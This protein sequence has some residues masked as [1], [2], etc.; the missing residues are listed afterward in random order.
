M[1]ILSNIAFGILVAFTYLTMLMLLVAAHE[2]GHYLFARLFGMGAEEF[3]VGMFGKKPLAILGK[4]RYLIPLK[5]DD[6]PDFRGD[7]NALEG[8]TTTEPAEVVETPQGKA[9]R[10]TT[11]FTIR[12]WPLGGFVRIK[13]M[14][15]QED[16]GETRVPGGFFSKP[17]IQRWI[18]LAAGPAFSVL[19]G[20][21]LLIPY[22]MFYGAP[23]PSPKPVFGMLQTD[24]A[25]YKAKMD[26]G[27]RVVSIDGKPV[28][29]WY[30][31]V[32]NVR[33]T[34]GRPLSIV[35]I[36]DGKQLQ[37][38]VKGKVDTEPTLV[39]DDKGKPTGE[40]RIQTK[41]GALPSSDPK[42]LSF[43]ESVKVATLMPIY[44]TANLI[45]LITHPQD[46]KDNVGGPGTMVKMTAKSVREGLW[47]V[48]ARAGEISI[49]LGIF[50]LLPIPP[51]D[52]GQMWI[53]FVEMLR[54]GRRLSM[55][56][57]MRVLNLGFAMVAALIVGVLMIDFGRLTGLSSPPKITD[58]RR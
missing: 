15:P 48:I 14:V 17:P 27:D 33:D 45:S 57:Q 55:R 3:A 58:E 23:D 9:L 31:M 12:P 47:P 38:T 11:V 36:R 22:L 18:V 21:L 7:T 19:A 37:F 26:V 34:N 2:L 28:K 32:K 10:E 39:V 20:I 6:D 24:G 30:D 49:S 51:L 35:A 43:G 46:L 41:L 44:G 54:R 50:N 8:G 42:P 1:E 25:A 56:T 52:G 16:G 40:K 29:T 5:S 13:G 53:A 4:R